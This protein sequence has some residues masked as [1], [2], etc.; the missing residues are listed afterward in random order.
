MSSYYSKILYNNKKSL[1]KK[2]RPGRPRITTPTDDRAIK[3]QSTKNPFATAYD[4]RRSLFAKDEKRPS[5]NTIRRRLDEVGLYAFV[6]A[7]KPL[8][9]PEQIQRRLEWAKKYAEW[10]VDDWREVVFSDESPFTL[11]RRC[12]K[13][14]VRRP[15]GTR[16]DP[17]YISPTVKHGGGKIQVWSCF[18]Y[19][20]V[21]SM[22]R[23][24][25]TMDGPK[26]RSILKT[27]MAPYLRKL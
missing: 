15:I 19:Y 14:Y 11:F 6:A 24:E 8:L 26:Y 7:Q 25:G 16:F 27:Y 9:K 17:R 10:T 20:S 21:G 2:Q 22:K 12:G 5:V 4:I 13:R 23:I 1:N 18:S 3:Y